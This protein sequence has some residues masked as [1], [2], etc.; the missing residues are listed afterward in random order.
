LPY[1]STIKVQ[2]ILKFLPGYLRTNAP[3]DSRHMKRD[4][5]ACISNI[6]TASNPIY[7]Y[8]HIY[9]CMDQKL[10]LTSPTS[11]G[12]SVGIVRSRT[13]ATELVNMGHDI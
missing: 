1:I 3:H 11:G 12:L 8:I 2:A 7:I 9:I 13:K 5:I 10:A 4:N 6:L